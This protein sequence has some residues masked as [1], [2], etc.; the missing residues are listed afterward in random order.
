MAKIALTPGRIFDDPFAQYKKLMRDYQ[1]GIKYY[2]KIPYMILKSKETQNSDVIPMLVKD[3]GDWLAKQPEKTIY[4]KENLEVIGNYINSS[5]SKFFYLFFTNGTKTDKVMESK[6]FSSN[7]VDNIIMNEV[8]NPFTAN[9]FPNEPDWDMLY[10]SIKERYNDVYAKR[11]VLK[12]KIG[13]FDKQ[14][15]MSDTHP[16]M[17]D[18]LRASLQKIRIYG[19]DLSKWEESQNIIPLHGEYSLIAMINNN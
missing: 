14:I 3:F 17:K 4:K 13:W 16:N 9:Y 7:I 6:Y 8:V 10:D 18:W 19:T 1:S 15:G 12:A 5:K 2:E 11:G